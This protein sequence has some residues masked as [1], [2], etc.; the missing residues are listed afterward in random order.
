[1]TL[2]GADTR[3]CRAETRLGARRVLVL[4]LSLSHLLAQTPSPR[5]LAFEE[6][7]EIISSFAASGAPVPDLPDSSS[8]PTAWPTWISTTDRDIR[9]RV[10]RGFEDSISNLI[11]FGTSFTTLPRL[12]GTEDALTANADLS[13]AAQARVRAFVSALAQPGKNERL[14]FAAAF[15]SRHAIGKPELETNLLRFAK[16]QRTYQATLDAAA[17]NPDPGQLLFTRGTLYQER[18]LSVDTS[19]LPNYAL[20]DT[21]RALLRKNALTP[22]AIHRVAIIGPGLDFADKRAGYDYYPL[23]TIQPFAVLEAVMRLGL[24]APDPLELTA[25]DLNPAVIAHIRD[26]ADHA[27]AGRAYTIQLPRDAQGGLNPAALAYWQ[28]FGDVIGTSVPPIPTPPS[29]KGT[30]LSRA[31]SIPPRYAAHFT[32]VDLDIV[33]QTLDP[34]PGTGFDL[35]VATNIL[36]Y[37]DLFHQA[38]AKAAIARMMNP[39]GVLLVNHAL[40][41]QPASLLEYLGRRSVSY[42]SA[43]TYGDDVVVYRRKP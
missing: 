9:N 18:G 32:A 40:P 16:E 39:G 29:L 36:V 7:R 5:F 6:A 38:M 4:F 37:Y 12:T 43:A 24:A 31:V 15:L 35:V 14:H 27:R 30:V 2:C 10:D 33:A 11:L 8:W 25:F 28:H 20:E 13:P 41:S 26:A 17:K 23:Q 42:S 22:G 1:V 21:L 34:P 3:V 19:L